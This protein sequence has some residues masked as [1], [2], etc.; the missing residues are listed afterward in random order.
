M[1]Y[2]HAST[3][4]VT[5][6]TDQ[7]YVAIRNPESK[8]VTPTDP[9]DLHSDDLSKPTLPTTSPE[10]VI[11][12]ASNRSGQAPISPN[13]LDAMHTI[14]IDGEVHRLEA[15][16]PQED[17]D[18]ETQGPGSLKSQSSLGRLFQDLIHHPPPPEPL[19]FPPG[20]T[21]APSQVPQFLSASP[22]MWG[23]GTAVPAAVAAAKKSGPSGS[24]MTLRFPVSK[25]YVNTLVKRLSC[26]TRFALILA[27]LNVIGLVILILLHATDQW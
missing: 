20:Q 26:Q 8:S 9:K 15:Q 2:D 1:A 7:V 19:A 17:L 4:P 5:V 11:S 10:L 21:P 13:T 24:A 16:P 22:A 25:T 6:V 23:Y 14:A 18:P 3:I 27:V 12:P